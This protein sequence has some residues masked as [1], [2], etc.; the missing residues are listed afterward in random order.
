MIK[1]QVKTL[2]AENMQSEQTQKTNLEADAHAHE[3]S[4]VSNHQSNIP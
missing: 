1:S 3:H 4:G 2:V